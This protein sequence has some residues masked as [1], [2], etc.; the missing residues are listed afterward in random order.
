MKKPT[1]QTA[2]LITTL[3]VHHF[4]PEISFK[5]KSIL[6]AAASLGA[7]QR[8]NLGIEVPLTLE[9]HFDKVPFSQLPGITEIKDGIISLEKFVEFVL[10]RAAFVSD[11]STRFDDSKE[12]YYAFDGSGFTDFDI[13]IAEE[14]RLFQTCSSW[15]KMKFI[16]DY[17]R[18]EH[19][20]NICPTAC[21]PTGIC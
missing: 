16:D 10:I 8:K 20:M 17:D 5:L 11:G 18:S 14:E 1:D 2:A 19:L 3:A 4:C 21:C 13:L 15:K 9:S 6:V 12:A 7:A